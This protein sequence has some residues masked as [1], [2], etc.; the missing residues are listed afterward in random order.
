MKKTV[1][2]TEARVRFGEIMQIAEDTNEPVIVERGGSPKVAIVSMELLH[3]FEHARNGTAA[4]P[5]WEILLE[6]A[7]EQIR[8]SGNV[9]LNPPPD[10]VIRQM[11]EERDAQ[12]TNL[13]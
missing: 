11:R 4:K 12:L 9:P 3:E 2:A 5:H 1:T 7:H 8:R 13:P 6:Q 10:E